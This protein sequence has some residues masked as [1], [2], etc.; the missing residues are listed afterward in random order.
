MTYIIDAHEDLAYNMLSFNRDYRRSVE[1]TRRL[2]LG[3][4]TPA[5]AGETLIGWPEYQ[6]GQVA[7]V[8]STL[9]TAHQ[10]FAH[11]NQESQY[12]RDN[13]QAGRL[14]RTQVDLYRRLNDNSSDQFRLI[15]TRKDLA[16]VL[17]PWEKASARYPER[18][19]PVGLVMLME[20]AEG[21]AG[22]EELEDWWEMGVRIIGPVW[23]GGRWC[24][25][26]FEPGGITREGFQLLEGM[27]GLGFTLDL[28]HMTEASAQ[29]A[30][31]VYEGPVIAS[32]ANARALLKGMEGER[33]LSDVVIRLLIERDGI[34]GVLPFNGFLKPGWRPDDNSSQI[35]LD[36]LAAHVDHICQ[37]AGDARHA[38]IGSDFD[39]GFGRGMVPQGMDS[40]ADLQKLGAALAERGYTPEDVE[41]ILHGN[42]QRHLERTLP[43][44]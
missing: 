36:T 29:Q 18:T 35:T 4:Q 33:H 16:E 30:L 40:I 14:L 6:R 19:H 27:S 24:G 13:D 44:S 37:L 17:K 28:A 39:G 1:E 23:A 32:H 26:S 12:Y 34:M 9:F 20:G 38:G 2:E 8:F 11:G 15:Y 7:V 31:D 22:V 41:L 21:I 42:W 25:G 3:S 5:Q 43:E 10:R